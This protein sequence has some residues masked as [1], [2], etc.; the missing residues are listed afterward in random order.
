[1]VAR[2]LALCLLA[3]CSR[4][5]A[6]RLPEPR[7][8]IFVDSF[9]RAD[10]GPEWL[11]TGPGYQLRGGELVVRQAH[12]HPAWLRK[13]LPRDAVIE[14]DAR[15]MDPAGDIKAEAYGDG[16]SYATDVEYTSTGYV[17]ILGGWHNTITALCRREEHGADRR[18][19]RD[20][21][22]EPGRRYHFAL[23]RHGS[24]LDWFL[25]GKP[26]L[27]L[28]DPDPLIGPDHQYF[29]FDDW[30]SEVHFDNV[31]IRPY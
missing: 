28:D 23:A 3:G 14:F 1:M 27:E 4:V 19:R 8:P 24:K 25:D 18:T 26:I 9:D 16:K 21:H 12:N 22:V 6:P 11:V 5:A 10:L 17:F 29:A 31:I 30:E 20:L 2:V 15:S 7:P 13:E